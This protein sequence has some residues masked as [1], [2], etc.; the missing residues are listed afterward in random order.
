ML[1]IRRSFIEYGV[2][3]DTDIILSDLNCNG[4]ESNLLECTQATSRSTCDHTEAAG[5]KCGG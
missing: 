1:P 4:L 2:A 5:V 3:M